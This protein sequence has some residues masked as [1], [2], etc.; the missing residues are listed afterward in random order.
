MDIGNGPPIGVQGQRLQVLFRAAVMAEAELHSSMAW[1]LLFCLHGWTETI[2]LYPLNHS[3][4]LHISW[5]SSNMPHPAKV[6]YGSKGQRI[7]IIKDLWMCCQASHT[8]LF[9]K[10]FQNIVDVSLLWALTWKVTQEGQAKVKAE[11]QKHNIQLCIFLYW[12]LKVLTIFQCMVEKDNGEITKLPVLSR[13][14]MQP[15]TA[16]S[17]LYQEKEGVGRKTCKL[18]ISCKKNHHGYFS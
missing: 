5:Q 8:T 13:C 12:D 9:C 6:Y 15:W 14:D 17:F 7:N 3:A 11:G 18:C 16:T 10:L 1:V 2:P 4:S